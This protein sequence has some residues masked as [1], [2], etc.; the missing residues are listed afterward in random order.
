MADDILEL[1]ESAGK[2][3]EYWAANDEL[4]CQGRRGG[5]RATG[6]SSSQDTDGLCWANYV[7]PMLGRAEV[8]PTAHK[9]PKVPSVHRQKKQAPPGRALKQGNDSRIRSQCTHISFATGR[10]LHHLTCEHD[11]ITWHSDTINQPPS[12]GVVIQ[13][14]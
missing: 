3:G 11:T 8:A 2:G 7:T 5:D 9:Q 13:G 12:L 1:M 6:T 14:A 4:Y 10:V